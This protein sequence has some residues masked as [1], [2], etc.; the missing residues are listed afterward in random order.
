MISS[1]KN[2]PHDDLTQLCKDFKWISMCP[3][4]VSVYKFTVND[5]RQGKACVYWKKTE[6]TVPSQQSKQTVFPERIWLIVNVFYLLNS[7]CRRSNQA[8]GFRQDNSFYLLMDSIQLPWNAS[9][10]LWGKPR[11][12]CLISKTRSRS[13]ELP[14]LA[15]N[16][17]HPLRKSE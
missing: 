10:V 12:T 9:L 13:C 1:R 8:N 16:L 7:S 17:Y 6:H 3:F 15:N 11:V 14:F 2:E 4:I 5:N